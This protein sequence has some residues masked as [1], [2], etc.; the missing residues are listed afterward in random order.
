MSALIGV[1]LALLVAAFA[2]RVGLDRDGGFYPTVL[3]V[4]ASYYVLFAVMGGSTRALV[5]E[6]MVMAAFA[7]L[8]IAGFKGRVWLVVAGLA[9]HG[10]MDMF[11]A[12]LVANSGVPEWW[13][14]FCA[15]YDVVAAAV[16]AWIIKV[17]A[18][19]TL[20]SAP[21]KVR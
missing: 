15:A 6:S 5:L 2:R 16:L 12:R 21:S 20:Y 4:V 1:T 13:P 3:I 11:H 10:V 14:P 9:G 19:P 8:A 18:R 17:P 7:V